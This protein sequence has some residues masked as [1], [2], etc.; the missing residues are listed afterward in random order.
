MLTL[1]GQATGNVVLEG[2][3]STKCII[4][5]DSRRSR[6]VETGETGVFVSAITWPQSRWAE[7]LNFSRVEGFGPRTAV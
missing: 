2:G 7:Q 5:M 1:M 3:R 4:S 6:F